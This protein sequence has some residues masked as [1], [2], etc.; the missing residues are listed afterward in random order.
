[1]AMKKS[2]KPAPFG[3]GKAPAMPGGPMGKM[4]AMKA[5]PFGGKAAKPK[6]GRGR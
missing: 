6:A 2:A 3:K 5:A 4:P 1:M